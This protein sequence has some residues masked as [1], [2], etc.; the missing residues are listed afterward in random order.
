MNQR[1]L[2]AIL[3]GLI[4]INFIQLTPLQA[5]LNTGL[6][7]YYPLDGNA[8]DASGN[9]LNGQIIILDVVSHCAC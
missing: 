7:A 1:L 2:T 5:D 9:G 8:N 4:H 3:A 6:I